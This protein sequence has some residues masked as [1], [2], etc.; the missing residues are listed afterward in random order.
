MN[1]NLVCRRLDQELSPRA[2][3]EFQSLLKQVPAVS[4]TFQLGGWLCGGLARQLLLDKPIQ[5]YLSP[6]HG[7]EWGQRTRA[8]DIDLFFPD[9]PSA[10][11]AANATVGSHRSLAGFAKNASSIFDRRPVSIQFVDHP[12]LIQTTIEGT[13]SHFDLVNCQVGIDGE[14]I[15]FPEDW[16]EI[17]SN[18]LIRI[19]HNETPFLGSRILKYLEYR[20]LEGLTEDSYEKLHGWFAHAANDFREGCWNDQHISCVK[21][22][23][24]K[25]RKRGLVRREDLIFFLNKWKIMLVERS[26]GQ[27]FSYETDWALNELGESAA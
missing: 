24:Q 7:Q 11:R 8:G 20:D 25:M 27:S 10:T 15:Y 22:H 23:V 4:L 13:L 26:Y 17:E 19:S 6:L 9:V 2:L 16:H 14:R 18:R 21:N 5:D 3:S 1:S 12:D